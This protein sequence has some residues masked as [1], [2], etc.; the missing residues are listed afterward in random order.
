MYRVR[1]PV[2]SERNNLVTR[3]AEN[4]TKEIILLYYFY[5][6]YY[7]ISVS[8]IKNGYLTQHITIYIITVQRKFCNHEYKSV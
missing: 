5:Y 8:M 6:Y 3:G 4:I 2:R 7:H 1:G